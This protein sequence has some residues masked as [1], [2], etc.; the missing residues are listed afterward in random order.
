MS[1]HMMRNVSTQVLN[2][3]EPNSEPEKKEHFTRRFWTNMTS[4]QLKLHFGFVL[5]L[6]FA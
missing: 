5:C 4:L 1:F 3:W 2:I 6:H